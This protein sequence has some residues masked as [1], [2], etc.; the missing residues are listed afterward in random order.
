M[1]MALA[2]PL[3]QLIRDGVVADQAELARV[4]HVTYADLLK[5]RKRLAAILQQLDH[6]WI[7]LRGS[8]L[9]AYSII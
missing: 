2:I 7:C 8:D 9:A 5:S 6:I 3:D 1:L 4:G